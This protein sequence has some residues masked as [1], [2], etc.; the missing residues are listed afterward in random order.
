MGIAKHIK[1][2]AKLGIY[3]LGAS[4]Y[5]VGSGQQFSSVGDALAV[6][7]ALPTMTDEITEDCSSEESNASGT[8]DKRII[9][10]ASGT[11]FSVFDVGQVVG[12]EI[13]G[14]G[15][16]ILGVVYSSTKIL[17]KHP[18]LTDLAAT[19][20][21]VGI[22]QYKSIIAMPGHVEEKSTGTWAVPSFTAAGA[23]VRG[24]TR[25]EVTAGTELFSVPAT[26]NE[27]Y[28][29]NLGLSSKNTGGIQL[30]NYTALNYQADT[31]YQDLDGFSAAQDCIFFAD[32]N[33]GGVHSKGCNLTG[34]Y[35]IFRLR[36]HTALPMER[37]NISGNSLSAFGQ[38]IINGSVAHGAVRTIDIRNLLQTGAIVNVNGNDIYAT[39]D[40]AGE[41]VGFKCVGS[42]GGEAPTIHSINNTY[43]VR[44]NGAGDKFTMDSDQANYTINRAGNIQISGILG[45]NTS[46]ATEV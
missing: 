20:C 8:L 2:H 14:S 16:P 5:T 42:A 33:L 38:D 23:L 37:Y 15:C 43:N 35:D 18:I 44:N 9:K 19:S 25:L 21:V 28:F 29:Y 46:A 41:V 22:P 12:V 39:G 13:D 27:T 45:A 40:T 31:Y 17:L 34:G 3:G 10:P 7:D 4:T 6:I 26:S 36:R 32:G 24:T 1:E 11:P 30:I